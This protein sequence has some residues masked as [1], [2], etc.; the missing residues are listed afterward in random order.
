[1]SK[2]SRRD[3]QITRNIWL[4]IRSAIIRSLRHFTLMIISEIIIIKS[5]S[6]ISV[7]ENIVCQIMTAV[8][9]SLLTNTVRRHEEVLIIKNN[10]LREKLVLHSA[11]KMWQ[12][13]HRIEVFIVLIKVIKIIKVSI[14]LIISIINWLNWLNWLKQL[15]T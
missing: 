9:V 10:N 4:N 13:V 11:L 6:E 2:L 3:S 7:S 14:T 15:K 12:E 5:Y 1:M 8:W